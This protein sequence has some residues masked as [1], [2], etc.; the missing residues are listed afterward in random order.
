MTFRETSRKT[1]LSGELHRPDST[2]CGK[3]G[4]P[5]QR[6]FFS[7]PLFSTSRAVG[8]A[9]VLTFG[10]STGRVF[11]QHGH[12]SAPHASAPHESAPHPSGQHPSGS[13]HLQ[14]S[15]AYGHPNSGSHAASQQHLPDWIQKNQGLSPQQQQQRL[16]QER[17]YSHLS[18]DEQR[19][20]QSTLAHVNQMPPDQRQRTLER[21]ENMERLPPERQQ[22]V[23]TSA[24]RFAQLPPDRQQAMREAIRNLRNV[25]PGLRQSQLN[26]PQYNQLSP[27]ERGIVGNLLTIESYHPQPPPPR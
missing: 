22:Q 11:A 27:E 16:Q 18:P 21:N 4:V 12:S 20:L 5:A 15:N 9:F 19:R 7:T 10:L 26:S 3:I 2:L 17:G 24:A 25:P 8:L 13:S 6:A 23:R 14:Q 1:G